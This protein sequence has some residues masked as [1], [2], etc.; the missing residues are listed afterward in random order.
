MI[1][2]KYWILRKYFY[3][4]IDGFLGLNDVSAV[5][6]QYINR[7]TILIIHT[8]SFYNYK[9]RNYSNDYS[10]ILYFAQLFL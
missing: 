10:Q 1:T 9:R 4:Y 5:Q 2:R 3:A 6:E 7:F 8:I